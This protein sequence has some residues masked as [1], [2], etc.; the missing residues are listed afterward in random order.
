M[1]K[2]DSAKEILIHWTSV[3]QFGSGQVM[4][5]PSRLVSLFSLYLMEKSAVLLTMRFICMF[6]RSPNRLGELGQQRSHYFSSA[7]NLLG[8]SLKLK[9]WDHWVGKCCSHRIS[10]KSLRTSFWIR[11]RNTS[12]MR[13]ETMHHTKEFWLIGSPWIQRRTLLRLCPGQNFTHD[14]DEYRWQPDEPVA[15][16]KPE[17]TVNGEEVRIRIQ[18]ELIRQQE[19]GESDKM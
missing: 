15:N 11:W 18:R 3:L 17:E 19:W 5:M 6:L 1:L 7:T 2:A 13:M 14:R 4:L 12:W 16:M 10:A 9:L 8:E